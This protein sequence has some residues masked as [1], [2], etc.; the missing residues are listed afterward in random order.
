[1]PF[2]RTPAGSKG[3]SPAHRWDRLFQQ[4]N[5]DSGRDRQANRPGQP[6]R[7]NAVTRETHIE[8]YKEGAGTQNG[9]PGE[10]DIRQR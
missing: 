7:I 10:G 4:K 2:Q 3:D 5:Q 8:G 9:L 1:M 6:S